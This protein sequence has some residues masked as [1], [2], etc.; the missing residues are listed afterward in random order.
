MRVSQWTPPPPDDASSFQFGVGSQY[1]PDSL[2]LFFASKPE[3][4]PQPFIDPGYLTNG[5][6]ATCAADAFWQTI[7]VIPPDR[8]TPGTIDTSSPEVFAYNGLWMPT[9]GGGSGNFPGIAGSLTI[10]SVD[11]ASVVVSL[12]LD[13][14]EGW[15]SPNGDYT[16]TFCQ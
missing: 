8:V 11:T 14:V 3:Q 6:P 7:L 9:C 1:G 5:D 15:P 12:D 10:H 4:C 2:L 13:P 16:A